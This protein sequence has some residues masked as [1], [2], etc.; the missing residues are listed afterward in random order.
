MGDLTLILD[1]SWSIRATNPSDGSHDNWNRTLNILVNIVQRLPIGEEG[2][3]IACVTFS[4][5]SHVVFNLDEH[6]SN[7]YLENKE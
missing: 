3:H 6:G 4:N 2:F 1:N 5:D 7:R